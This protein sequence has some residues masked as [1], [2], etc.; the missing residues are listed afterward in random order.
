[1]VQHRN[2]RDW[3]GRPIRTIG[4]ANGSGKRS[5]NA[6]E[7][8]STLAEQ[9]PLDSAKCAFYFRAF[10]SEWRRLNSGPV[11]AMVYAFLSPLEL[12]GTRGYMPFVT[13]QCGTMRAICDRISLL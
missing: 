11:T 4:F 6:C 2:C 3:H 5:D 8:T 12:L 10:P 1:M 13:C 9:D 7:S